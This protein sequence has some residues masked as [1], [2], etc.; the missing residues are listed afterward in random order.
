[1]EVARQT[2]QQAVQMDLPTRLDAPIQV[3]I[4]WNHDRRF[5]L[6]GEK[7]TESTRAHVRWQPSI[8]ELEINWAAPRRLAL[9]GDPFDCVAE[10]QMRL[11][12]R[13]VPSSNHASLDLSRRDCLVQAPARGVDDLTMRAR[14]LNW[15]WGQKSENVIRLQQIAAQIPDRLAGPNSA[16]LELGL[17]RN[18]VWAD[19]EM[20]AD[21]VYPAK[22]SVTYRAC[23]NRQCKTR[24]AVNGK[25]FTRGATPQCRF[26]RAPV[27]RAGERSS[28]A[29]CLLTRTLPFPARQALQLNALRLAIS[30]R[31]FGGVH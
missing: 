5:R 21:L 15:F 20:Q 22:H 26:R 8:L 7:R 23:L 10:G 3:G 30:Y 9:T 24:P 14:G 1:M 16:G 18:Q 31:V 29:F 17:S 28:A 13:W 19:W 11:P 27:G 12:M 6:D 2:V 4:D 25:P